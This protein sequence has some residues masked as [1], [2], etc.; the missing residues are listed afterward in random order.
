MVLLSENCRTQI[1]K[2]YRTTTKGDPILLKAA[3]SNEHMTST[4]YQM[5]HKTESMGYRRGRQQNPNNKNLNLF[6]P[7]IV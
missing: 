4:R 2:L 7:K 1:Q 5:L 6:L 3:T